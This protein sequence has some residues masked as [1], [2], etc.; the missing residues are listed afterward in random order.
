[1][2]F[3]TKSNDSKE[4]GGFSFFTNREIPVTTAVLENSVISTLP[5]T[6]PT[7]PNT[8]QQ[9]F[10]ESCFFQGIQ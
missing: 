8:V 4:A 3:F 6:L 1:M 2:S 5:T 7:N 10:T 9:S